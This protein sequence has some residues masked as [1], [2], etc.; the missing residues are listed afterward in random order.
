MF[1][2][3]K[4]IA[5]ELRRSILTLSTYIP[6]VVNTVFALLPRIARKS[7]LH[8]AVGR[9]LT[10]VVPRHRYLHDYKHLS[11]RTAIVVKHSRRQDWSTCRKKIQNLPYELRAMIMDHYFESILVPGEIEPVPCKAH[12]GSDCFLYNKSSFWCGYELRTIGSSRI[13]NRYQQRYWS[14]NTL[15]SRTWTCSRVMCT[16]PLQQ[17]VR[18]RRFSPTIKVLETLPRMMS[19]SIRSVRLVLGRDDATAMPSEHDKGHSVLAR[20]TRRPRFHRIYQRRELLI[21]WWNAGIYLSKF[22]LQHLVIDVCDA[23]SAEGKWLG[24]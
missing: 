22:K 18:A 14:E 4:S 11:E 10:S 6:I 7:R 16:Y 15:V 5:K 1:P 12:R 19:D 24:L 20:N 3:D 8:A 23:Y 17:I 13:Y 9:F 2:I 21:H